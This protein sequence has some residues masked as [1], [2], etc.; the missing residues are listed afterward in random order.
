MDAALSLPMETR[1]AESIARGIPRMPG[2]SDQAETSFESLLSLWKLYAGVAATA[3]LSLSANDLSAALPS[4]NFV[5]SFPAYGA[6][7]G[8]E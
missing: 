6:V 5:S 8:E 3:E 2:P 7:I 4:P 1:Y